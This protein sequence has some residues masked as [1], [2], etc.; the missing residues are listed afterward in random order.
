MIQDILWMIS[1]SMPE[2][3]ETAESRSTVNNLFLH[4]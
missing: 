2:E 1:L 3:E 4:R